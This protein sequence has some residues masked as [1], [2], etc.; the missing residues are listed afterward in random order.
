V[1]TAGLPRRIDKHFHF[2]ASAKRFETRTLSSG[3][4]STQPVVVSVQATSRRQ[5]Y[6]VLQAYQQG[7]HF[8]D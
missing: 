2:L 8:G 5:V 7:S 6:R 4:V 3:T 1:I